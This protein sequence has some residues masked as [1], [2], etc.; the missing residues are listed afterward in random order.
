MLNQT[1]DQD[2]IDIR[3]LRQM[4]IESEREFRMGLI[5]ACH[6]QMMMSRIIARLEILEVKYGILVD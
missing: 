5:D 3:F 6:Y 2:L 4:T 1:V